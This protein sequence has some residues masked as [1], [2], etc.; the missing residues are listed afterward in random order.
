M[1]ISM[2]ARKAEAKPGSSREGISGGS[3]HGSAETYPTSIHEDEGSIPGIAWWVKDRRHEQSCR[4]QTWLRSCV[5]VA[6][7]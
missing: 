6:V 3:P 2:S 4:L 1:L 5:A 7:V